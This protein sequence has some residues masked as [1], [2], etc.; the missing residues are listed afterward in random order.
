M[1]QSGGTLTANGA[2]DNQFTIGGRASA[3]AVG[4]YNLVSGTVNANT[5]VD[6]GGFGTGTITQTGGSFQAADN[7]AIGRQT[8]SVGI[9]T[10]SAGTL[11]QSTVG[12]F[13]TVG[14]S[15]TGTLTISGTGLV[16]TASALR[17]GLSAGSGTVNLNGGTLIVPAITQGTGTAA[18]D[19]S[20]GVL[21]PS[22]STTT[23]M[24][25][26]ATAKV[27]AGGAI[28]NTN[29]FNITVATP[30]IHD[31]ALGPTVDGGL[32][33]TGGGT[34]T[35]TGAES[36]T[37]T[38][39]I[40]AGTLAI[41][42]GSIGTSTAD[43][44]ISPN[45]TDTGTLNV[46]GGTVN[47]QRV[48]I[49]GASANTGTPGT[50]AVTLSA[51]T[52]NSA[53]WFTVGSGAATATTSAIG[54]FTISGGTLN[55]LSQQMEVANFA[56][57]TGTVTMSGS[58]A[59]NIDNNSFIAL[60]ANNGAGNGTFTQNGGAVTFYGNA[61]TTVGGTGILYL[62]KAAVLSGTY[63]YNLNGGTLTVPQISAHC[64]H[65]HFQLQRRNA[66]GSG[67]QCEL[68]A[69]IDQRQCAGQRRDDQ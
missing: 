10:I 33:K 39:I 8:K 3:K 30:L 45:A 58:S 12:D 6:D 62:G 23:F 28:F 67:G 63:T 26:G 35:F 32:D 51:G 19:F 66:R 42:A 31:T 48:I 5:N 50:G 9:W 4:V 44:Q 64:G 11:N 52:I 53:Q 2:S 57:T 49:A 17:L 1:N 13:L 46:A 43:I 69:G 21:E 60:G 40:N 47:A 56:G 37:G 54:S 34:L 65:R 29:G 59:I 14:Q 15:G 27:Q 22:A 55:V 41:P 7:V 36:Y 25:V 18:I 68:H 38:T 16:T 24:P 61:G 20:G